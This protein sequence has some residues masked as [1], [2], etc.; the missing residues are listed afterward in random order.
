MISSMNEGT[1]DR[2]HHITSD[3]VIDLDP[4]LIREVVLLPDSPRRNNLIALA[5]TSF[6]LKKIKTC[7]TIEDD[8]IVM[9]IIPLIA[10]LQ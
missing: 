2:E 3:N 6:T 5:K 1:S 8:K 10:T 9:T 7:Y 4:D